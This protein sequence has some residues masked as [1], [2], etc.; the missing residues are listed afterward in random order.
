MIKPMVQVIMKNLNR[1]F[2]SNISMVKV[3]YHTSKIKDAIKFTMLGHKMMEEDGMITV[4]DDKDGQSMPKTVNIDS[5]MVEDVAYEDGKA[6]GLGI[7]GKKVAICMSDGS[8]ILME[9]VAMG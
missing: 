1:L 9:T 4:Y 8:R 3:T 2:S 7:Y 5:A 6:D